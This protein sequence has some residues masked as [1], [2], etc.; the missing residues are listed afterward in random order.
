MLELKPIAHRGI[1]LIELMVTVA[2]IAIIATVAAPSLREYIVRRDIIRAATEL[3]NLIASGITESSSRRH[4]GATNSSDTLLIVDTSRNVACL[5]TN[6]QTDCAT[7][8][9]RIA[10]SKSCSACTVTATVDGT[11]TAN[12]RITIDRRGLLNFGGGNDVALTIANNSNYAI[13]IHLNRLGV[14]RMCTPTGKQPLG[15][16]PVC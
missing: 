10:P 3:Q 12:V 15:E 13:T 16:V 1:T 8:Y 7:G 6:N 2:I 14:S 4:L 9:L 5:T 11:D